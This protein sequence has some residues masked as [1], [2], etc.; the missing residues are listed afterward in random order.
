[1]SSFLSTC[2][3]AVAGLAVG[4]LIDFHSLISPSAPP[5]TVLCERVDGSHSCALLT[6]KGGCLQLGK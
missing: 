4:F 1:M 3:I 6:N 2:A 5:A